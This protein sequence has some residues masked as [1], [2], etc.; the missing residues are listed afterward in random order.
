M[1]RESRR[2]FHHLLQKLYWKTS[3]LFWPFMH[4]LVDVRCQDPGAKSGSM[5]SDQCSTWSWR[6][7]RETC[8]RLLHVGWWLRQKRV[9]YTHTYTEIHHHLIYPKVWIPM[10][11]INCLWHW[12]LLQITMWPVTPYGRAIDFNESDHGK[13]LK[14]GPVV[15]CI[16]APSTG[17]LHVQ[18][19]E[20]EIDVSLQGMPTYIRQA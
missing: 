7:A 8:S 19:I 3:S 6:W 11:H 10:R 18:Y 15:C 20:S 9:A 13:P 14:Q 16:T 5:L 2:S 4:W 1:S 12:A 17:D